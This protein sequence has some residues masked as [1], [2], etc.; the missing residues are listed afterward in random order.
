MVKDPDGN[1]AEVS[2]DLET[3]APGRPIGIWPHRPQTL[4]QWG[5]ALMRS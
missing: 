3:C 2:S 5:V 4:N 1:L